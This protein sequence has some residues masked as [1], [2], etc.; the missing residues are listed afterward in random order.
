MKNTHNN[1]ACSSAYPDK[2]AGRLSVI[3]ENDARYKSRKDREDMRVSRLLDDTVRTIGLDL[4]SLHSQAAEL[5]ERLDLKVEQAEQERLEVGHVVRLI[6]EDLVNERR[7]KHESKASYA[8]ELE[9]QVCAKQESSQKTRLLESAP[10]PAP[11]AASLQCFEGED[12]DYKVRRYRKMG[13]QEE[14]LRQQI[15]EREMSKKTELVTQASPVAGDVSSQLQTSIRNQIL[16]RGS[17]QKRFNEIN[18]QMVAE[19]QKLHSGE[20]PDLPAAMSLPETRAHTKQT[21]FKGLSGDETKAI[22]RANEDLIRKQQQ[23]KIQS[24]NEQSEYAEAILRDERKAECAFQE[25]LSDKQQM[26]VHALTVS[27]LNAQIRNALEQ[28]RL[29][30]DRSIEYVRIFSVSHPS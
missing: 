29:A 18:K 10:L 2:Y 30:Q 8:H 3:D 25:I 28:E 23:Q 24:R 14:W 26:Q 27:S 11:G 17:T 16:N 13:Q 21:D 15:Y 20:T 19:K 9:K 5:T 12:P 7:C 4:A 22:L 1:I 6:E